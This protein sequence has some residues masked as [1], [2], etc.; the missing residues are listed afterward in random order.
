MTKLNHLCK[1]F[2]YVNSKEMKKEGK[3]RAPL[4]GLWIELA[5]KGSRRIDQAVT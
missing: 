2:L 4:T 1:K 3:G 5:N